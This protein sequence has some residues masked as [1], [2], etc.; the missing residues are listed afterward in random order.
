M[1][2]F[3][4]LG[5]TIGGAKRAFTIICPELFRPGTDLESVRTVGDMLLIASAALGPVVTGLLLDRGVSCI[6]LLQGCAIVLTVGFICSSISAQ[7]T[8][9]VVART[10]GFCFASRASAESRCGSENRA[11]GG[12]QLMGETREPHSRLGSNLASSRSSADGRHVD[13]NG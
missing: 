3:G 10:R 7:I 1:V 12:R 4:F 11:S 13:P 6:T 5:L 9:V 2:L 8:R